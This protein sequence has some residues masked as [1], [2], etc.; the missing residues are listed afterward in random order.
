MVFAAWIFWTPHMQELLLPY[1]NN[2]FIIKTIVCL[3]IIIYILYFSTSPISTSE[4]SSTLVSHV[5][6]FIFSHTLV[7]SISLYNE[8]KN[9]VAVNHHEIDLKSGE[10]KL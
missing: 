4:L 6:Y 10:N 5:G 7:N 2:F 1:T 9:E 3:H 8:I